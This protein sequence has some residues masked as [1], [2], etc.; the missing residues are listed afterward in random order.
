ML[1]MTERELKDGEIVPF[2][3]MSKRWGRAEFR[4]CLHYKRGKLDYVFIHPLQQPDMKEK[5]FIKCYGHASFSASSWA[6]QGLDHTY[7][8]R[9]FWCPE[10]KGPGFDLYVPDKSTHFEVRNGDVYFCLSE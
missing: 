8:W 9:H 4:F 6:H 1:E 5:F 10:H 2:T 3:W 7:T